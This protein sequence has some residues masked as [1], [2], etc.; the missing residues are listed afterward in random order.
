MLDTDQN[1]IADEWE[2]PLAEKFCPNL[3]LH[4]GDQGVRPVPVEIMD[5]NGDYEMDWQD[6]I[7]NVYTEAGDPIG[8]F[9]PSQIYIPDVIY[10]DIYPYYHP[11]EVIDTWVDTNND[12]CFSCSGDGVAPG[13]RIL[14]THFEWGDLG[15]TNPSS[16][17]S[18]WNTKMAQFS[19]DMR[20]VKG[21]TYAHLFKDG[22]DTV[23]QYWFF[24]PFN[25]SANRH[26][27]DWE[28]INVILNSQNPSQ[29][30]INKV[31]YYYHHKKSVRNTSQITIV[32]QTHPKVYV[33]GYTDELGISGHGTH[34]SYP[35]PG[36]H[37]D[38]NSF[39]TDETVDGQG[40]VIDFDTYANIIILPRF[41]YVN[42]DH[43]NINPYIDPDGNNLNWMV[44]NAFWGY[45][46]SEP[47]AG[48]TIFT[49]LRAMLDGWTFGVGTYVA[50]KWFDLPDNVGNIAAAGPVQNANWEE[51]G[52]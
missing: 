35:N 17:Y 23:I 49:T 52:Y 36:V 50:K 14:H 29:A 32:D 4:S 5:R 1:G 10:K 43:N 25:A 3:T 30:Q 45:V 8:S 24:Y 42:N 27:G 44:F 31:V 51:K 20:Y 37:D 19:S 48:Y 38:I 11:E 22:N 26:E 34:G 9:I 40:L 18:H 46:L 39:G 33:G 47:S 12:G 16:W 6:V 21:T 28:H 15:A 41:G 2:L 13:H 7:V